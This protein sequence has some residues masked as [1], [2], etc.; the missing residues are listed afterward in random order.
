MKDKDS[1]KEGRISYNDF[2]KW[3]GDTI[4]ST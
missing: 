3:L 1:K 2:S 4:H